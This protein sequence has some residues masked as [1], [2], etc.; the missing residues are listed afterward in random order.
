MVHLHRHFFGYAVSL[1][2]V[3]PASA[4]AQGTPSETARAISYGVELAFRSGH[5]DRGYLI[6]DRPVIQPVMWVSG[7][8]A[9]FSAWGNFTLAETTEGARPKILE[10]ELTRK[11]EWSNLSIGPAARMWFY[12]DPLSRYSSRSL[13]GWLYVSY[14]AGPLSLFTNH[15]LDVMEYR[16]A[17]FLDAGIESEGALSDRFEIGG[18]LG[19]GW[20]SELFNEGWFG[21]PK[22]ALN[23]AIA[24]GWLTAYLTPHLYLVPHFEYNKTL[25]PAVRA[26]HIRP[27]YLLVGLTLGGE[28]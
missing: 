20:A 7:N 13:E 3:A 6:S 26:A 14:D 16:G 25:D 22:S 10:L 9:D 12:N 24:K 28:F 8:G 18:S 4:V 5:A 19:A 27:T 11:F 21:V 23:R 1:T 17:Y 2:L 15:S